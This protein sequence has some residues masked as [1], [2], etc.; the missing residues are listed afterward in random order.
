MD[1][2]DI[3]NIMSGRKENGL[4]TITR[5]FVLRNESNGEQKTKEMKKIDLLR[6][7]L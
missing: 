7:M 3:K 2:M 1:S 5:D 6:E 4:K